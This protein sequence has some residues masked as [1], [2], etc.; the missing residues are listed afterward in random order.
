MT[1]VQLEHLGVAAVMARW[2]EVI[3]WLGVVQGAEWLEI[4]VVGWFQLRGQHKS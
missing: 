1:L 3:E 2:V 4:W